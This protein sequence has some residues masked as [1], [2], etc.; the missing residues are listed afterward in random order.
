MTEFFSKID[1]ELLSKNGKI[2]HQVWF[3]TIPNKKNAKKTYDKLKIYRDSWKDKNPEWYIIEWN[4]DM[5]ESIVSTFYSK[6]YS[7]YK[8]YVYEIQRCDTVRYMILHRYGGL[9]VDM[10]YFCNKSFDIVFEKYQ[11]DFY[12][13]QTPNRSGDYVS[14]SLMYSRPNH[15]FWKLLLFNMKLVSDDSPF[16]YTK[17]VKI[18]YES[19]PAILNRIYHMNKEKLKLNSW[20]HIYFQPYTKG[21][22]SSIKNDNVYAIH[23][24]NGSWHS[25]DSKIILFLCMEWKFLLFIIITIILAIVLNRII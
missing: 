22:I 13:V 10:D 2:I 17:H 20:P 24:S 4:K 18:M 11:S 5:C 21:E 16:Y 7:M 3:G 15:I 1:K 12:L 6:Y 25:T 19:G 23:L 8:K 14:N 9:Y